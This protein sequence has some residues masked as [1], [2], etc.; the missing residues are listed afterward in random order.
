MTSKNYLCKS[1]K[2]NIRRNMFLTILVSLALLVVFPV[3]CIT[4]MEGAGHIEAYMGFDGYQRMLL[5]CISP[6]SPA[7]IV[8]VVA[9]VLYA[10]L[11]FGYLYS[12][13]KTDF[14]HSLPMK[15]EA[16]YLVSLA[17]SFISF[18]VPYLISI[19]MAYMIGTMSGGNSTYA[20]KIMVMTIG[21]HLLY[22]LVF[23]TG[24][25]L[26]ILLT[27]NLFTGAL[28][29]AGIMSYGI[30]LD[31]AVSF[32]NGRFFQTLSASSPQFASWFLSPLIIYAHSCVQGEN[33][34]EMWSG[35][36]VFRGRGLVETY[37]NG[38]LLGIVMLV[39][40]LGLNIWIYKIR[41]SESYHKAIAF[42]KLEPVIKVCSV[43][44]I[45]LLAGLVFS[46]EMKHVFLWM[47]IGTMVSAFVLS[48]AFNF[49]YTLDIRSCI[50]PKIS[51]GIILVIL[52][53]VITGYR[54]DITGVDSFL[55][56]KDK[57]ETMSVQLNSISD[58]FSYP[59]GYY[60]RDALN[61]DRL[62][63]FDPVYRLAEIGVAYYKQDS[64]YEE[65][66]IMVDVDVAFHMKSGETVYRNYYIPETEETL[67]AIEEIYNDWD[68]R[69]KIMPTYYATTEDIDFLYVIDH[70][71]RRIQMDLPQDKLE[72]L[73]KTYKNELES[74]TFSE[75]SAQRIIGYLSAEQ[76][77]KDGYSMGDYMSTWDLPVY[78]GF[79]ETKAMLKELGYPILDIIPVEE[80]L[81]IR[82]SN[83]DEGGNTAGEVI[84][85]KPEDMER[86]LKALSYGD[87]RYRVGSN[88]E[89][90]VN[91][92]ISW[93]DR[94]KEQWRTLYLMNNGT[95]DDV[96]KELHID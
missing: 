57:I 23:Y 79:E 44:P 37:R 52:T 55:P 68:Y 92:E 27:G 10:L 47:V 21:L 63:S 43:I 20:P 16:L 96:L 5:R 90:A 34:A 24:A 83:L 40:L 77:M 61:E 39:V 13:E 75:S 74:M 7:S 82:L 51:D 45:S 3:Y 56:N 87:A 59:E 48:T 91:V 78:E 32:M 17:S 49:L 42:P 30:I 53:L 35:Q 66:Q 94:F 86:I 8:V 54:M 69:E 85:E 11:G 70:M 95:L 76:K 6:S 33:L 60:G 64:K 1:I 88:M 26:A 46:A 19:G 80:V 36:E 84:L 2:E 12:G 67:K 58:T 9:A 15:R 93:N 62:E 50:K 41:S 14:Y 38:M 22:Y 81:R 71:G 4:C 31:S 72:I 28:G 25:V 65:D 73:Y 18:V 89:Y 29:F